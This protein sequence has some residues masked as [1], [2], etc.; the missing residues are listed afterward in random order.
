MSKY[1]RDPIE[2]GQREYVGVIPLNLYT[3]CEVLASSIRRLN[4]HKSNWTTR[5][6]NTIPSNSIKDPS[7]PEKIVMLMKIKIIMDSKDIQNN[8]D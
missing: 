7:N 8:T 3:G 6:I 1:R 5:P 2:L 4:F